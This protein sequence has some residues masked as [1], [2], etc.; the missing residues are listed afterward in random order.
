MYKSE[1]QDEQAHAMLGLFADMLSFDMLTPP[2]VLAGAGLC[3]VAVRLVLWRVRRA[4]LPPGPPA[5]PIHGHADL[6]KSPTLHI[7]AADWVRAYGDMVTLYFMDKNIVVLNSAE[8]ATELLEK[9][10]ASTSGRQ[11][12]V[13]MGEVMG[14]NTSVGLHQPDERFRKLRRVMASAMHATAVRGYQPVE[15]ENVAYMLRRMAGLGGAALTQAT[16]GGPPAG[17][18]VVSAESVGHP[19]SSVQPMGLVRE[20]AT[21]FILRVAYGY[22]V[23]PHDPFIN[24]IHAAMLKVREG[25]YPLVEALPWRTSSFAPRIFQRLTG[26]LSQWPTCRHGSP[27]R[28]FFKSEPRVG[29]YV[30]RTPDDLLSVSRLKCVPARLA[31]VSS[32]TS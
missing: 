23:K 26:W 22:D 24:L 1:R 17:G 3:A 29:S 19:V 25:R 11:R 4:Q 2:L 8:A 16:Q 6:I 27:A 10:A 15:V 14:Y 28:A 5:H 7:I 12:E 32:R 30:K 31:R 13:M 9:R 18:A 20:A 21:R